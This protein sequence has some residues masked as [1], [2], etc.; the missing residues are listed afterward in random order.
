MLGFISVKES[1]YS[2]T[3]TFLPLIIIITAAH[4]FLIFGTRKLM[5]IPQEQQPEVDGCCP[6]SGMWDVVDWG[7]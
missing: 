1:V 6:C 3:F 2:L 4:C 7:E 5:I